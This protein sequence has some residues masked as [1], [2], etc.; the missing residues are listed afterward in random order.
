MVAAVD[1]LDRATHHLLLAFGRQLL[2]TAAQKPLQWHS[3]RT[4][5]TVD[6]F[7][8]LHPQMPFIELLHLEPHKA[9]DIGFMFGP[10]V[11]CVLAALG[12]VVHKAKRRIGCLLI[13]VPGSPLLALHNGVHLPQ[14]LL[15]QAILP[16]FGGHAVLETAEA[17]S[18]RLRGSRRKQTQLPD[19][20]TSYSLSSTAHDEYKP[21]ELYIY[22]PNPARSPQAMAQQRTHREALTFLFDV[23]FAPPSAIHRF[24]SLQQTEDVTEGGHATLNIWK[25]AFPDFPLRIAIRS[26]PALQQTSLQLFF[27]SGSWRIANEYLQARELS[28]DARPMV[29]LQKLPYDR[30]SRWLAIHNL[31]QLPDHSKE[32]FVQ[33][34]TQYGPLLLEPVKQL[35]ARYADALKQYWM[36]NFNSED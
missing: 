13:A 30:E 10:N 31:S 15:P 14:S 18:R 23:F 20:H 9:R 2:T 19:Q 12:E 4:L 6:L 28:N 11:D 5:L 27:G 35:A 1:P 33:I 3:Q 26:G 8:R 32:R 34:A 17:F 16:V 36:T 22:E 7:N 21:D 24:N 25:W 29:D